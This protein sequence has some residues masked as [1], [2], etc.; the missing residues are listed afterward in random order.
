M[1][2]FASRCAARCSV[3]VCGCLRDLVCE[4]VFLRVLVCDDGACDFLSTCTF[5]E[6]MRVIAADVQNLRS[7]HTSPPATAPTRRL[8]V[9]V[10]NAHDDSLH[11]VRV[12][13]CH[14]RDDGT[15]QW[16]LFLFGT[17][18]MCDL[19]CIFMLQ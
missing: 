9:S 19:L 4:N 1:L 12:M 11:T 14:S 13:S 3:D 16:I 15:A 17:Y 7:S 2:F 18:A 10:A 8:T 5:D 6:W